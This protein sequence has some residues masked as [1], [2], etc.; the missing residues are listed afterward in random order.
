MRLA[1]SLALLL[2]V[3]CAGAAP[4]RT[5]YLL[6]SELVEGAGPVEAPLHIALGRVGVAPYLDQ[7]GIVVETAAGEVHAARQ[8]E[9]AEP[10]EAGLRS[11]LRAELSDAL[12]QEVSAGS[13]EGL[14]WHY[15][16]DVYVDRLHG[17]MEGRAVL[18]AAYWIRAPRGA[19]EDAA[20]RFSRSAPLPREGYP[21]LVEA[22]AGLARELARAI[23]GSLREAG[24]ADRP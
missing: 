8:H 20:Y 7:S 16:V 14:P 22:E 13:D 5:L 11:L 3:A 2:L 10:L 21:G 19:G 17:T 24:V 15:R 1:A 4:P 9:W 23:A 6:R 18:D 12:G